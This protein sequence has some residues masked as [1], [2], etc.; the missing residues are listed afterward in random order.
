MS[1]NASTKGQD[2]NGYSVRCGANDGVDAVG[3]I[4]YGSHVPGR[5]DASMG[6]GSLYG[7]QGEKRLSGSQSEGGMCTNQGGA[8]GSVNRRGKGDFMK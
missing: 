6:R 7:N 5:T 1:P 8:N 2:S 3:E 4:L